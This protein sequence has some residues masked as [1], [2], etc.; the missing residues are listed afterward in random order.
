MPTKKLTDYLANPVVLVACLTLAWL[1]SLVLALILEPTTD[2]SWRQFIAGQIL[3][4]KTLYR[5]I[6][7]LNPPLWFWAAIPFVWLGEVFGI[8]V[9]A[10][11]MALA[12]LSSLVALWMFAKAIDG[13]LSKSERGAA[14]LGFLIAILWVAAA[15]VGQRE[16]SALIASLLWLVLALRRDAQLPVSLPL[17]V[18]IAAFSAYG[19]A[20]K[21]YFVLIPIVVEA[22]LALRLGKKWRPLRPETLGLAAL[23][24]VYAVVVIRFAP[25][26]LAQIVPMAAVSYDAFNAWTGKPTW[27]AV[28]MI[29]GPAQFLLL[30]LVLALRLRDKRPIILGLFGLSL[31]FLLIIVGQ[32]KGFFYHYIALKGVC[33][34]ILMLWLGRDEPMSKLDSLLVRLGLFSF[35]VSMIVSPLQTVI[36]TGATPISENLRYLIQSEPPSNRIMIL[37][38]VPQNSFFVLVRE[39]QGFGARHYSMWMVPG[40]MV[41]AQDPKTAKAA[42]AQLARVRRDYL[43]DIQCFAPNVLISQSEQFEGRKPIQTEGMAFLREDPATNRWMA[44]HYRLE[45]RLKDFQVWRLVKPIASTAYCHSS[46]R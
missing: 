17:A 30:P 3:D 28:L 23:A 40:L 45:S 39:G 42:T 19:F 37:S 11:A 27:Y 31:L 43:E 20:L 25:E 21:H 24:L 33:V 7:D 6:I 14:L 41:R 10:V 46:R 26:F 32:M 13:L 8:N 4:G 22:A 2:I 12:H 18:S 1:S 35:F 5:D 34:M 36:K 29:I 15:D 9:Q 16:Q 44:E 38:T